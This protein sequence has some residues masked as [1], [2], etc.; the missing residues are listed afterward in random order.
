M[1]IIDRFSIAFQTEVGL[2]LIALLAFLFILGCSYVL[3]L[4]RQKKRD[5]LAYYN[6]S[7]YMKANS[8]LKNFQLLEGHK[9][10]FFGRQSQVRCTI[11]G[12]LAKC[13]IPPPQINDNYLMDRFSAFHRATQDSCPP[14][15]AP[16]LWQSNQD[17]FMAIYGNLFRS[18]GKP[19][20]PLKQHL[21]DNKLSN[22]EKETLLLDLAHSL[23]KLHDLHADTGQ[24]LYH[25]FILPRSIYLDVDG[26]NKLSACVV[27]DLGLAFALDAEKLYLQLKSL[28]K[29]D[30]PIEKYC[31]DELIEQISMLAPEQKKAD[32]LHEV[33]CASDFYTFGA[34]AVSLFTNQRF[35]S[36]SSVIWDGISKKWHPFLKGCLEE[37]PRNRPKDFLECDD[38]FTDPDL[39]LT[40][41]D[42]FRHSSEHLPL[43]HNENENPQ[44]IAPLLERMKHLRNNPSYES[45]LSHKN[46]SLLQQHLDA[47]I[48]AMKVSKWS[49]ARNHFKGA[50]EI[51]PHH[52]MIHAQLAIAC[53]ELGEL[54]LAEYHHAIAKKNDP[55]AARTFYDHIAFKI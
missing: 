13:I 20:L 6:H 33:G 8:A 46:E 5:L 26:T 24:Q 42:A 23:A 9:A 49:I 50:L 39:A 47:G 10:D 19:L 51:D 35:T 16:C 7:F 53:Y 55:I 31:A 17:I 25:G 45:N 4:M 2:I 32:S 48:K 22:S 21:L 30:L 37:Y 28:R 15:F 36:P 41:R 18:N 3:L 38:W 11:N 52:A 54:N 27:S 12:L 34:L 44:P 14:L 29:G 43:A 40:Y 1:N